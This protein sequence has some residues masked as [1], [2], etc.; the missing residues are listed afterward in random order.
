M[1]VL[2]CTP[3]CTAHIPT[4]TRSVALGV[5]CGCIADPMG[6]EAVT[7]GIR[8]FEFDYS[9]ADFVYVKATQVRHDGEE[10]GLAFKCPPEAIGG[11]NFMTLFVALNRSMNDAMTCDIELLRGA[12]D[13]GIRR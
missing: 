10:V 11:E 8:L 13:V 5:R 3:T 1:N 6:G 9:R 2:V 4:R 12:T 7:Q